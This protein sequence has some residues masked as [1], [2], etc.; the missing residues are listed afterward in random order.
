MPANSRAQSSTQEAQGKAEVRRHFPVTLRAVPAST[1]PTNFGGMPVKGGTKSSS[2]LEGRYEEGLTGEADAAGGRMVYLLVRKGQGDGETPVFSAGPEHPDGDAILAFSSRDLAVLYLQVARW[3]DYK[4]LDI[5][6]S[7]FSQVVQDA[8][9]NGI[10]YLMVDPNRLE[11]ERGQE[12]Q[13]L[14]GIER[15]RDLSG[16]NLYQEVRA[17]GQG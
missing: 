10:H 16:E 13:P 11:Q 14:L 1:D 9:S 6:P 15:L 12:P 7:Q 8:R 17:L 2:T 4:L 3:D 5:A